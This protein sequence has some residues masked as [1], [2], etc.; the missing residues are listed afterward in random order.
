[1]LARQI[2]RR[3]VQE[4]WSWR[5]YDKEKLVRYIDKNGMESESDPETVLGSLHQYL[6]DACDSCMPKRKYSD[7][8]K[9][10]Y[11]WN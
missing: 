6:V 8:K 9:P 2:E 7:G 5:K 1:L 11:W 4:R 10:V 3:P